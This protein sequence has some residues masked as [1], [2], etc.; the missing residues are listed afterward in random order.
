[1]EKRKSTRAV[2]LKNGKVALM[3]REKNGRKYYTFPGGG[4]EN[5]E[6]EEDCVKRECLEEFGI[7]V[8]PLNKLYSLE[9]T[10]TEQEFYFCEWISG[11]F[12]SGTGEEFSP[13][14]NDGVFKPCFMEIEKI[15]SSPVVPEEIAQVVFED[16]FGLG[17]E[18]RT[19]VLKIHS[20]Y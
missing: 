9:D 11:E 8:R 3:Y 7:V 14:K 18:N 19:E 15:T 2:I 4:I 12:G 6:S 13:E 1:M 5:G 10:K 16:Y 17:L 20:D